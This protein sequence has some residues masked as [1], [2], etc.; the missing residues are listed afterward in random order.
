MINKLSNIEHIKEEYYLY[1]FMS[2]FALN[3]KFD[4]ESQN[5]DRSYAS[6]N[7][8]KDSNIRMDRNKY[9]N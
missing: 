3:M 7:D 9:R 5:T 8:L 1:K 2:I 4:I 6:E